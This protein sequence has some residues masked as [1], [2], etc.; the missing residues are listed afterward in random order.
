MGKIYENDEDKE[1]RKSDNYGKI[2]RRIMKFNESMVSII[3]S[4]MK[5]L[6]LKFL[7][8]KFSILR[9]T[10]FCLPL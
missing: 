2:I 9:P 7:F 6:Y 5:E 4:I 3:I 8:G 10:P 1:E